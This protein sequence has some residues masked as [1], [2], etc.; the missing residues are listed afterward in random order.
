MHAVA[1]PAA[2]TYRYRHGLQRWSILFRE[3]RLIDDGRCRCAAHGL[4]RSGS[5]LLFRLRLIDE[6]LQFLAGL[7]IGDALGWYFHASS[8]LG[9]PADPGLPLTGAEASITANLDFVTRPQGANDAVKY[10]L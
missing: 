4:N 1:G 10:R 8:G 5:G 6:I 9:I 2:V 7:E 3:L